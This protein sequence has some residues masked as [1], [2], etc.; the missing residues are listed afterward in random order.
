M[1]KIININEAV[2]VLSR[3]K[4][5]LVTGSFDILHL[6]HLRFLSQAKAAVSSEVKLMVILLSDSEIK[7][8]KG[9]SRPIFPQEQR[10]EALSYVE[11]VDYVVGWQESWESLRDFVTKHKPQFLA[12]SKDDPGYENKQKT[13]KSYGGEVVEIEKIS[14]VSTSKIIEKLR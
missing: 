9:D 4:I 2:D 5:V 7:R 11:P 3:E 12:L 6:G 10:L 14:G 13:V 1:G 8:R